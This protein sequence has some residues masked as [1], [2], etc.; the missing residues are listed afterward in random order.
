[1]SD[2]SVNLEIEAMSAISNALAALSDD[3]KS[4]VLRWAVDRYQVSVGVIRVAASTEVGTPAPTTSADNQGT[5][6][7]ELFAAADPQSD[8]DKALIGA[9]WTQFVQGDADFDA[10]S[11]NTQLKHLGHGV[12]NI[13][14]AL[15][16][17]KDRRP[18]LVIQ[19]RKS[20]TS[21]Q[22]RKKYRITTAGK[23]AV[24]EMLSHPQ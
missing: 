22:A 13:T 7:A 19:L 20:G 9:Y 23:A 5:D 15:E 4:R 1:M 2:D 8:A 12:G 18:Q 21:K 6:L 10:Q 17:L 16:S 11:V 3:A 14:R 24:E